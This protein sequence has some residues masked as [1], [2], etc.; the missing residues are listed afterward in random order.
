VEQQL[1]RY[2]KYYYNRV[3][4]NPKLWKARIIASRVAEKKRSIRFH[5]KRIQTLMNEIVSLTKEIEILRSAE[6]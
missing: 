5:E 4:K 2:Q 1:S 3:K 6:I